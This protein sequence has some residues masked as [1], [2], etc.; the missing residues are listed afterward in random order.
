MTRARPPLV[1]E[2]DPTFLTTRLAPSMMTGIPLSFLA[3]A[4][5]S[6]RTIP[7]LSSSPG[8]FVHSAMAR[9]AGRAESLV[10]RI[11]KASPLCFDNHAFASSLGSSQVPSLLRKRS[12]QPGTS[13]KDSSVR[14][15]SLTALRS[16]PHKL[17]LNPA[18]LL[19]HL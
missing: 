2:G 7:S 11:V 17:D 10:R 15:T 8:A 13:C 12:S 16:I 19:Y 18:R 14:L 6:I 4:Y 5:R 1:I 3:F 9:E